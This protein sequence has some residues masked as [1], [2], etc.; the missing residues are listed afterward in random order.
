MDLSA[1]R[2]HRLSADFCWLLAEK[3]VLLG[4]KLAFSALCALW[5]GKTQFG[6][7]NY[8]LSFVFFSTTLYALGIGRI[9]VRELN[10]Q[11]QHTSEILVSSFWARLAFSCCLW[12]LS[13]PLLFY[14]SQ[15][16][17]QAWLIALLLLG[18]ISYAA[19]V[20]EF[21]FQLKGRNSVLVKFRL[22]GACCFVLVK[23]LLLWQWPVLQYLVFVHALEL[24]VMNF[25][26]YWL[27]RRYAV[28]ELSSYQ[29]SLSWRWFDWSLLKP[30]MQQSGYLLLSSIAVMLYL[31]IDLVM[32][33]H[34]LGSDAVADYS[35]A[36][37]FSEIWYSI[38][39]I[40]FIVM[41]PGLLR[42]HQQ[43]PELYYQKMQSVM[44]GLFIGSVCFSALI[45]LVAA[46]LLPLLFG[47]EFHLALDILRWHIWAGVLVALREGLSQW[48]VA[49]RFA[50]FSLFSHLGGA[51]VNLLL[52]FWLIPLYGAIGAAWAT[53][54]AYLFST[55]ICLLF[56]QRTRPL[57]V[58]ML[59]AVYSPVTYFIALMKGRV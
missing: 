3:V 30:I 43:Q 33:Q 12:C 29:L 18:N 21:W 45:L 53:G 11:P 23:L 37:Q 56:F 5:L 13:L 7:F 48:L 19:N 46:F 44:N 15:S 47:E 9:L 17:L 39:T 14:F 35:V 4:V 1:L 6:E 36:V 24:V 25:G 32:L 2:L 58:M 59:K 16:S 42:L 54:F 20:Y 40:V 38:P 27:F 57:A 41:A 26:Y 49:E 10:A 52:N 22:F 51:V 8:L 34:M 55:F 50:E 28:E 31:R